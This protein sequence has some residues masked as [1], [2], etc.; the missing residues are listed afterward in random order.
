[1]LTLTV[2][3]SLYNVFPIKCPFPVE[4]LQALC[5]QKMKS[6]SKDPL[7]KPLWEYI[8]N[9]IGIVLI[10][11]QVLDNLDSVALAAAI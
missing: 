11:Q 8:H 1:M 6:Y 7:M 5:R 9:D 4:A 10:G 3:D 2:L